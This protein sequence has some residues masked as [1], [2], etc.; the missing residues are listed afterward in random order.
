M[1]VITSLLLFATYWFYDV[2]SPLKDLMMTDLGID[3]GSFGI[4]VSATKRY[5]S[6]STP[7]AGNRLQ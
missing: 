2:F 3:S 4:V 6:S 5:P 7:A 1:L